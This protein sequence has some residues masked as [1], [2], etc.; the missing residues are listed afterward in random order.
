[1]K[2]TV[3]NMLRIIDYIKENGLA[4]AIESFKL[5]TKVY[6]KKILLK[7]DQIESDM[8]RTEVQ[9]CRG[10]ILER[11]TWKVMSM[12]FSKFFNSGETHA[13]KIDWDTAIVLEKLDGTMIQ[14]YYDWHKDKWFAATT[15][16]AE[17][18]GEVNNKFGTT[19][20]D[21]FWETLNKYSFDKNKLHKGFTYVFELTT[22]YN[23]IVKPHGESTVTLL[24]IRDNEILKEFRYDELVAVSQY[25][26][27]PVV[28]S[29]QLSQTNLDEITKTFEGMPWSEEGYV[30][31]DKEFNRIKIK[32]P[33]YV[34]V[35]HLKSKTAEHNILTIVKSNEIEEF[36]ATF[37]E[38]REELYKLKKNYDSLITKLITAWMEL[39]EK[40]PKDDSASEKKQFALSVFDVAKKYDLEQFTGLFF[41]LQSGKVNHIYEYM[42]N[43][44]DKKLYKIL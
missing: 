43:Y 22:P 24:T 19:F 35:H 38:R 16:M 40:K 34:A 26:G 5:K 41:A 32:N 14:V 28:K 13:A 9:E 29:Y 31:I 25:F 44:D 21:L 42:Q 39:F 8:S 15:G 11:D 37:P 30:V 4:K 27:L 17:G 36:A 20:N 7:Y 10:L 3:E 12:S 18:E 2:I 33:A 1:M 23:I 6:D